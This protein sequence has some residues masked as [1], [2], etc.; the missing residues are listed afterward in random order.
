MNCRRAK[1]PPITSDIVDTA[2]V[3]ASPG[4]PSSRMC[5]WARSATISRSIMWSWPTMTFF[6]S[7][8]TFSSSAA[9]VWCSLVTPPVWLG[10]PKVG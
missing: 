10:K 7:K 3:L 4:R 6:T 8:I 1:V 9:A 2:S 5:P